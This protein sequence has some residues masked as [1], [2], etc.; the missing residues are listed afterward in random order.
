MERNGQCV[1][2]L[3]RVSYVL[4]LAKQA[5]VYLVVNE[6]LKEET[7]HVPPPST[8][9]RSSFTSLLS[10]LALDDPAVTL[11]LYRLLPLPPDT[12][13]NLIN[14]FDG[15]IRPRVV[16]GAPRKLSKQCYMMCSDWF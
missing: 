6:V 16:S 9:I 4:R 13:G 2:P 7:R 15:E 14:V 11:N 1:K 10:L 8:D 5:D 12:P 3:R